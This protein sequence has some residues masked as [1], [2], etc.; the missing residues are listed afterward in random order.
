MKVVKGLSTVLALSSVLLFPL[1]VLAKADYSLD[2]IIDFDEAFDPNGSF[3]LSPNS[4]LDSTYYNNYADVQIVNGNNNR[5]II[6]QHARGNGLNKA[7]VIIGGAVGSS[8]STGNKAYVAQYGSE[9]AG[10]ITQD[11]EKNIAVLIQDGYGH[12]GYISQEGSKNIAFLK[13]K[14][15]NRHSSSIS[16]DQEGINNVALVV[17]RGGSNYNIE[18]NGGA[19]IAV[20]SSMARHIS[21]K[22]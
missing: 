17:D 11:G 6:D 15:K 7:R 4:E 18:Q 20:W 2:R 3:D 12:E 16:I 9:N 8:N 21:I 5:V 13:Q 1:E 10:L 14:Y 19:T 22:Q